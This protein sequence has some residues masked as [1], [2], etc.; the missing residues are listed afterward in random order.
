LLFRTPNPELDLEAFRAGVTFRVSGRLRPASEI[1]ARGSLTSGV[2]EAC[3]GRPV[4]WRGLDGAV[5]LSGPFQ[6][7]EIGGERPGGGPLTHC[8]LS[9][10]KRD[11]E[12]AVPTVDLPLVRLA[13]AAA[14]ELPV[15]SWPTVA[16]DPGLPCRRFG[17]VAANLAMV[18]FFLGIFGAAAGT[19]LAF[20]WCTAFAVLWIWFVATVATR[21]DRPLLRRMLLRDP[22]LLR[23]AVLSLTYIVGLLLMPLLPRYISN[24]LAWGIILWVVV[25]LVTLSVRRMARHQTVEM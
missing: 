11:Y 2:L 18:A 24:I 13:L 7:N 22:R 19:P 20:V 3:Q 5:Q 16:P 14:T 17:R 10:G 8:L 9:T 25:A 4:F 12:L 15:Q 6:L 1:I 23:D 21:I